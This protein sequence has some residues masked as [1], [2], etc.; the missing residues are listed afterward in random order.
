MNKGEERKKEGENREQLKKSKMVILKKEIIKGRKYSCSFMSSRELT[1]LL[2]F[3][4]GELG[5]IVGHY[6]EVEEL[7]VM[8][9]HM[10]ITVLQQ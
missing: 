3:Q 2:L 10:A 9:D 8:K 7:D 5:P 1:G 4:R 6:Q